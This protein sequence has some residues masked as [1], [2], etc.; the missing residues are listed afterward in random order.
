MI[1]MTG[2]NLVLSRKYFYRVGRAQNKH[3][4]NC[5]NGYCVWWYFKILQVTEI[6]IL[7]E[8]LNRELFKRKAHIEAL[9]HYFKLDTMLEIV[10]IERWVIGDLVPTKI[11]VRYR[12]RYKRQ[13]KRWLLVV[14]D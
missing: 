14:Y 3:K 12:D 13:S 7:L 10:A 11:Q 8:D 2:E 5:F 1:K 9:G 4:H 6:R